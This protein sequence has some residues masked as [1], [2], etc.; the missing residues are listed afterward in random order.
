M[1]QELSQESRITVALE[2]LLR[3]Y[4]QIVFARGVGPGLLVFLAIATVPRLAL[5]TLGALVVG[6]LTAWVFGLG[7]R[8]VREG[9]GATTAILST[10]AL[11][12]FAPGG[13]HPLVLVFFAAVLAV[14]LS[15]SFEA[16]FSSVALP[17]HSL[18][19]I[20]SA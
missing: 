20:A 15:A 19:F 8:V 18:P 11:A 2:L 6:H 9:T 7:A 13:G 14:L 12:I 16:V 1:A 17:T 5:A 3:P 4:A 10:L